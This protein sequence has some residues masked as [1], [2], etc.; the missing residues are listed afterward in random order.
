MDLM[1]NCSSLV[2]KDLNAF[3]VN[4]GGVATV[5]SLASFED[6]IGWEDI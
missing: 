2:R 1:P 6:V 4:V 3:K 5:P